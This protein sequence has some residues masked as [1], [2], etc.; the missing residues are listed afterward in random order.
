MNECFLKFLCFGFSGI[1]LFAFIWHFWCLDPMNC[2]RMLAR[3]SRSVMFLVWRWCQNK[4]TMAAG[5]GPSLLDRFSWLSTFGPGFRIRGSQ[6]SPAGLLIIFASLH[7]FVRVNCLSGPGPGWPRGIL[8]GVEAE[9]TW[10]KVE[11]HPCLS[12]PWNRRSGGGTGSEWHY[13]LLSEMSI[14]SILMWLWVDLQYIEIRS[15]L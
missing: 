7:T 4:V 10:G 6:V 3:S 13:F 1:S 12:L 9:G 14:V 15:L 8:W 11:D 2:L 5:R